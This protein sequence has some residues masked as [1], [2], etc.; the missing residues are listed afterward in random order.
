M[1]LVLNQA[2]IQVIDVDTSAEVPG[3]PVKLHAV[4]RY[5]LVDLNGNITNMAEVNAAIN[6]FWVPVNFGDT[7]EVIR[8]RLIAALQAIHPVSLPVTI[9]LDTLGLL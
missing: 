6:N 3:G 4:V 2:F 5:W 8:V 7:A 9:I 1:P